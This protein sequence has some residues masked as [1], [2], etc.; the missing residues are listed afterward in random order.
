MNDVDGI[1]DLAQVKG[2]P[3]LPSPEDD[4]FIGTVRDETSM[5]GWRKLKHGI[6]MDSGSSVDITPE[7]ENDEF[8][9]VPLSGPRRGKRLGAANG[10]PIT[11]SGE[12]WISFQTKE[13]INLTWPFIAGSVKKTLKSVGTTCDADNYVVFRKHNGYIIREDESAYIEFNRVGNIYSIDVWVRI[14][15]RADQAASDFTRQVAAR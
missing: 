13:G 1:N 6:T 9:I 7:D 2:K 12:K 10:T 8:Q 15:S 5:K 4:V 14:G 11:V 3:V